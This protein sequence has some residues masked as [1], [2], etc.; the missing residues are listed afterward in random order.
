[1]DREL[2]SFI[3][4]MQADVQALVYA[5]GE[6]ASF[7]DKFTEYCVEALESIEETEGANVCSYNYPGEQGKDWKVNGYCL[8]DTF[9]EDKGRTY[10]E[11]LD[12]FISFFQTDYYY[13]VSKDVFTK[14]LNQIK[15]FL[16]AALKGHIDYVDPAHEICELIKLIK[17]QSHDFD[18]VNIYFLTN[19]TCSHSIEQIQLKGFEEL[20][21]YVNV[22]DI[23]RFFR[24]SESTT[25]R[26]PLLISFKDLLPSGGHGIPCLKIPDLHEFYE[27][28]L[29]IVPG[30]V[31]CKLY[32]EHS[33][34]LLESNVRAF[35]GQAGT[36]N[37]GIKDTIRGKPEMF[38]PYNNGLSGTAEVVETLAVDNQLYITK[39][40][41]FQ[42]VNGGQTT[43]SIY[44]T[45]KKYKDVDLSKIFVQMK[46]TVIKNVEQ[47]NIEV[48]NIAR[49]ANSQNKIT[50]L[51]LS[52][53]NPFL[54]RIEELSRR[55]YVI[56]PEN[57]NRQI[58][59]YFERVNGQYREALNKQTPSQQQAFKEK[60]PLSLKFVKSDVAKFINLWEQEPHIVSLGS[61]KNFTHYTKKITGLV[62]KNRLPGEYFYKKLI[63][64]AII[65]RTVDR[66]FGRKNIDAIGDTNVKSFTV[67]YTIAYFHYLTNNQLN[68]W[69]IYD[70]QNLSTDI[71]L[72]LKELILFVYQRLIE[73][74][75]NTLLSEYAKKESTWL[76]LKQLEFEIDLKSISESII[77]KKEADEREIEKEDENVEAEN[78]LIAV[79][80]ITTLG[81]KFWDGFRLYIRNTGKFS[82]LE[83][84]IW[85]LLKILKAKK[86]IDR[87]NFRTASR[88]LQLL[89][90]KEIDIDT[91]KNLSEFADDEKVDL[92]GIYD[93]MR[94]LPKQEWEKG[95][96]I[97]TQTKLLDNLELANVKSIYRSITQNEKI[98]ESSLI[99]ADESLKKLRRFGF[100]Y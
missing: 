99:K 7:E 70:Q 91:I 17:R 94:L 64:N 28:Y 73:G 25:K 71:I 78:E 68:L 98:K 19:G 97:I 9:K 5:E 2:A 54:V 20:G 12:L 84:D 51:D 55:K 87:K 83:L 67:A 88:V 6:G 63:A 80:K 31:L 8:R 4:G 32:K 43:A 22:W 77:T 33:S 46:L 69:K 47:K 56:S 82:D 79:S 96:A 15:R 23:N 92:K 10:F 50:D 75:N 52:S 48:P 35:L 39:L 44:H 14:T 11:T 38:L 45:A 86:N 61:L 100:K 90:A 13:N 42:I 60:N 57:R 65:F 76:S 26:E 18:R 34:K 89:E 59:W 37:K 58:L 66:L 16:N 29:A 53:N 81:T 36:Y 27:C 93:R 1:M 3:E 41:D 72:V 30:F 40:K 24:L 95:F 49:F 21:I 85:D 62:A 74:A